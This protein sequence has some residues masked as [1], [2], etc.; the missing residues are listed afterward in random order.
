MKGYAV[1]HS[2]HVIIAQAMVLECCFIIMR[3][4]VS[5]YRGFF[6]SLFDYICVRTKK[7]AEL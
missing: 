7:N 4:K 5:K 6:L 3:K 1:D 2:R